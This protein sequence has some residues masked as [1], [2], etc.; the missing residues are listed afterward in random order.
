MPEPDRR[1]QSMTDFAAR[2]TIMVD[3]QVRPN[4]V[5]KFPIIEA[6]LHVRRE[7]FVPEAVREAAYVGE[8]TDLGSGR[9]VL[10]P[11]TFAK[12]LDALDV[13]PTDRVLDLGAGFG[14]SA[15]VIARL[16][17]QVVAV[18]EVADLAEAAAVRLAA[19]GIANVTLRQGA[20]AAG[21]AADGPF[22][23]IAIEGAVEVVPAALLAQLKDG[24]RIGAIF[25]E[26]AL[27]LCRI[28]HKID[29]RVNWRFAFN[30]TAPVLPGFAAKKAFV[31]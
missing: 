25:M 24:G 29:G 19:E 15:A 20:L 1:V 12:M 28:G 22:D 7:A 18:E 2:R 30:A 10:E 31:F 13:Q 3:T 4:D 23:R 26:G 5:T 27:G 6:M 11:R 14:Y 21:S 9:V 16:G 17:G 8:N